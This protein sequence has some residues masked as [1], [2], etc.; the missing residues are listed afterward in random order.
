[1]GVYVGR[2]G[3]LRGWGGIGYGREGLWLK[4]GVSVGK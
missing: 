2:L 1:M 3:V 4:I